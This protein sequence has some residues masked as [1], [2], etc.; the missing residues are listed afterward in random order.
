MDDWHQLFGQQDVSHN[1]IAIHFRSLIHEN[2]PVQRS[3]ETTTEMAAQERVYQKPV[4][5]VDELKRLIETY[6]M[7]PRQRQ[8]TEGSMLLFSVVY[9][10]GMRDD[11]VL[12]RALPLD[13]GLGP[14]CSL[15]G[16][17]SD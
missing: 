17:R 16:S 8:R 13:R 7:P 5:Y 12:G 2:K 3:L 15:S 11:A 14:R 6:S 9:V 10:C 4:V 1:T